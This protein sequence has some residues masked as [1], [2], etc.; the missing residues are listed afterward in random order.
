MTK[1]S[2][3]GLL[4][5]AWGVLG[6]A[7][8]LLFAIVRLTAYTWEAVVG[9]LNGLHW[10]LLVT[11]VVFMA[12]SEGYRGFQLRFSPRVAARALHLGRHVTALRAILAPLF[13][14]GYFQAAR[15]TILVAWIGT[16]AIVLVVLL[17]HQLEQPWRG[18]IDAGVVVGL[19]WGLVTFVAAVARTFST[20][21]YLYDPGVPGWSAGVTGSTQ[22][23]S[24]RG[25][26][27]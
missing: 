1:A 18:I 4:A 27:L 10:F 22:S 25:G 24:P 13:C 19:T 3:T 12:W 7:A 21:Q 17:V 11:N 2:P 6:V 15:R 9:G 16:L 20:G 5:A 8:I 26:P 23:A 14:I